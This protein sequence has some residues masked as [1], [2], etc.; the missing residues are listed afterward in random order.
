MWPEFFEEISIQYMRPKL[1][2]K[3]VATLICGP[4]SM[5]REVQQECSSR[6]FHCHDLHFY[7]SIKF[8][9]APN[10][11]SDLPRHHY[12]VVHSVFTVRLLKTQGLT[13]Q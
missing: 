8:H 6:G 13:F 9:Q 7:G 5:A 4:P 1:P 2:G 10:S 11:P 3:G 12:Q